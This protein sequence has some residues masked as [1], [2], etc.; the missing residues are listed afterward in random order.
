MQTYVK[1]CPNGH[2]NPEHVIDCQFCPEYL[3]MISPVPAPCEDSPIHACDGSFSDQESQA[4]EEENTSCSAPSSGRQTFDSP[5]TQ[6]FDTSTPTCYLQV[7]G[8]VKRYTVHNGDVLGQT[9][10]ESGAQ[11]QLAGIAGANCIHRRHCRF[12]FDID[13]WRITAIDQSQFGKEFNN[14]TKVNHRTVAA[15][16]SSPL[17]NGDHIALASVNLIVQIP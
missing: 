16:E 15:S 9:D 7:V 3:G 10:P 2:I 5:V 14:P 17:I 12:D 6:R 4:S 13:G 11:L 1:I 8:A